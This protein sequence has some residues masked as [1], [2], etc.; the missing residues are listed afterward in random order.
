[1]PLVNTGQLIQDQ[2]FVLAVN[3]ITLEQA[4][5]YIIAAENMRAGLV[6]QLSENTILFHGSI[7]PLGKALLTLANQSTMP[8]AVHLDHATDAE[9]VLLGANLGFSSV[10][11]DGSHLDYEAN[12]AET[13]RLNVSLGDSIW[14]EAELGEVGG[15]DGVHAPGV[16]T[17]PIEAAKFVDA[18]GVDGLAVAV[19]S[20]HAMVEKSAVL[21]LG[22]IARL[23]GSV[24]VPL[25]LHGSS[26]VSHEMLREAIASGIGK[27]NIATELNLVYNQVVANEIENSQADPRKYLRPARKQLSEYLFDLHQKL[28]AP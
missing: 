28:V 3:V 24:K 22:L 6:L 7:E 12:V 1:M 21:D 14:F 15:K 20:S 5:A 4:E 26:G 10:M 13:K 11:F 17:D 16:R 27:I 2:G 23:R 9:L 8:I 19:G 25:V 18:T